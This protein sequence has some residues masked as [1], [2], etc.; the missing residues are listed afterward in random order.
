[1]CGKIRL[2]VAQAL[3]VLMSGIVVPAGWAQSQPPSVQRL[4]EQALEAKGD[5]YIEL[6][7]QIAGS[8][9]AASFLK[10]RLSE[11]NWK[12][13]IIAE[14]IL[15]RIEQPQTYRHY[16]EL[17]IVPLKKA[18][19]LNR[20]EPTIIGFRPF[21]SIGHIAQCEELNRHRPEGTEAT[22]SPTRSRDL[23]PALH[24]DNA[25]PFL[26]EITLKDTAGKLPDLASQIPLAK[27]TKIYSV[28]DA[29]A[30]L[31]VTQKTVDS[32]RAAYLLTRS[33]ERDKIQHSDLAVFF[34][35]YHEPESSRRGVFHEPDLSQEHL[36]SR[37][38]H[39]HEAFRRMMSREDRTGDSGWHEPAAPKPPDSGALA[40]CYAVVRL[41]CLDHPSILPAL[42]QS[43][44]TDNSAH[45][46][47][48]AARRLYSPEAVP[49]LRKA[50]ND[51]A[52]MVRTAAAETL[53]ELKDTESV[54][55]LIEMLKNEHYEV[56]TAA[57]AALGSMGD[58]R[59]IKPLLEAMADGSSSISHVAGIALARIDFG[60]LKDALRHQDGPVRAA[61][62]R[63]LSSLRI[64]PSLKHLVAD[65]RP[66]V[67]TLMAALRDQE[68]LVRLTAA[69]LLAETDMQLLVRALEDKSEFA[70]QEAATV[71]G[72]KKYRPAVDSLIAAL[73]DESPRVRR[74]AIWA[75][76]QIR[77]PQ[78]VE[79]LIPMLND[80]EAGVRR[81]ALEAMRQ[82]HDSRLVQP[83]MTIL[84]KDEDRYVRRLACSALRTTRRPKIVPTMMD[85]LKDEDAS[86]RATAASALGDVGGNQAIT[87][88]V[89]ALEDKDPTV[90]QTAANA[91]AA[92]G[93]DA[94]MHLLKHTNHQFRMIALRTLARSRDSDA[95][96]LLIAALKDPDPHIRSFAIHQLS[97]EKA[98]LSADKPALGAV[99]A[100]LQDPNPRVR[101]MTTFALDQLLGKSAFSYLAAALKDENEGV[102]AS[103]AQLLAQHR[104]RSSVSLLIQAVRDEQ[105]RGV[106]YALQEALWEITGNDLIPAQWQQWWAQNNPD[107]NRTEEQSP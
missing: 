12:T 26:V 30:L 69:E 67:S 82:I 74:T 3:A 35:R 57:I 51:R 42:I 86:I 15:G 47:A 103:A 107:L 106:Q 29:A 62:W 65:Y 36:D 2:L 64:K 105:D 81:D 6:R 50:L 97:R 1:M 49:A 45:V 70:R 72:N 80:P 46:R 17:L 24:Q 76:G 27:E 96:D 13:T 85:M 34:G 77:G 37:D 102:R 95:V 43:L 58:S 98:Q 94:A 28:R 18:R 40:R 89:A 33:F 66:D 84:R 23:E 38:R 52:P 63:T 60:A 48:Y 87:A 21:E 75:L 73:S 90:Q 14:A 53:G 16:E 19:G 68:G 9:D 11:P 55:A 8:K 41:G 22:R 5:A 78:A 54:P 104:T 56:T 10:P 4:F 83:L 93:S 91:L 71:L 79:A 92:I 100:M 44:Q 101:Q 99:I 7:N 61:A 31:G 20:E 25:V 39:E 59:A 88:L 32:W